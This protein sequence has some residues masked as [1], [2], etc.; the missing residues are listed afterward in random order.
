MSIGSQVEDFQNTVK[1]DIRAKSSPLNN[2]QQNEK[3][4]HQQPQGQNNFPKFFGSPAV[5]E[6]AAATD[7][8]INTNNRL[9]VDGHS[10]IQKTIMQTVDSYHKKE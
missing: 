3:I 8:L 1:V 7:I 4:K 5:H 2:A 9:L 10:V 6:T